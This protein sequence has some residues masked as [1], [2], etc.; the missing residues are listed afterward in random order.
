MHYSF[1]G[2]VNKSKSHGKQNQLSQNKS[3]V[4]N[5]QYPMTSKIETLRSINKKT[6][7]K[8]NNRYGS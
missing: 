5:Q 4:M 6:M 8:P 3:M 7:R 2:S 1:G